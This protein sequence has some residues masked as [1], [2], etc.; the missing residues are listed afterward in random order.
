LACHGSN[1]LGLHAPKTIL[2]EEGM[3]D[4]SRHKT[5]RIA[6]ILFGIE[7]IDSRSKTAAEACKIVMR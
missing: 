4:N 3:P 6:A 2:E 5:K 7:C 1:V